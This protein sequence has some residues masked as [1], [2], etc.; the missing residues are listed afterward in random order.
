L[1]IRHLLLLW[2]VD[3]SKAFALRYVVIIRCAIERV[4]R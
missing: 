4:K 2:L 3:A 1:L